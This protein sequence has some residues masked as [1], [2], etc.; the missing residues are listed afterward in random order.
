MN[1]IGIY[2]VLLGTII[3]LLYRMNDIIIYAN[4]KILNRSPWKTYRILLTYFLIFA[5]FVICEY[6]FRVKLTY[7]NDYIK[8]FVV[9]GVFTAIS[10]GIYSM[11][12]ILINKEIY[13]LFLKIICWKNN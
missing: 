6:F 1:L 7:I 13:Y 11:V 5:C 4:K 9:G 8:F 2:G 10:I 3:A 12:A